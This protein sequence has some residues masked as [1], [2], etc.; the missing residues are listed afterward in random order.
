VAKMYTY[1]KFKIHPGK[2]EEF[3]ALAA[4][5]VEIVREREPGTLFYEWFMN[6]AASACVA[7]DCYADLDAVMAHVENIGPLMRQMLAISDRYLE[8]YGAD[9]TERFGGRTTA[10]ASDFFGKHLVGKPVGG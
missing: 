9:P 2:V 1:A 6:D 4:R 10:R 3:K 8:I 5:C 7:L